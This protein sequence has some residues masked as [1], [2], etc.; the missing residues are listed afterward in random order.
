[1]ETDGRVSIVG[2][3]KEE[4]LTLQAEAT[5]ETLA[6]QGEGRAQATEIKAAAFGLDPEFFSFV[7]TL[8]LYENA[9]TQ[10]TELFLSTDTPFL[11]ILDSRAPL[12]GKMKKSEIAVEDLLN[13]ISPPSTDATESNLNPETPSAPASPSRSRWCWARRPSRWRTRAS[14]G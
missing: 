2:R 9:L 13:K 14:A 10:K 1:M 8:D 7:Q 3:Q 11:Q 5:R 6:L 4:V 12:R